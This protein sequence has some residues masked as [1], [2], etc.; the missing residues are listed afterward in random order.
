MDKQHED[1]IVVPVIQ[2]ELAAGT[3]RIK[4]GSIRVD[5]HVD[6]KTRKIAVPLVH[7][8]VEVRRVALNRVIDKIPPIR[9]EGGTV[10]VPVVEEELVITKRLILKEEVHLIRR[11]TRQR[12]LKEVEVEK[13]RAD[14]RRLD[15]HGRV[16]DPEPENPTPGRGKPW[17]SVLD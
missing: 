4:T 6:R 17:R 14:V 5:K 12:S 8:D 15:A 9:R 7:D 2:E 10:I 13:E 3:R 1:D 16:I 11:R